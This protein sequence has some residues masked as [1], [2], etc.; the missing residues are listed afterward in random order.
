MNLGWDFVIGV[1][2]VL[3]WLIRLEA[4]VLYMEK[5]TVKH[6]EE[7]MSK[8]EKL[9][10]KI[11]NMNEKMQTVLTALAKLEGYMSNHHENKNN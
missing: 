7:S 10:D 3:I 8:E 9:W 6:R 5:D 1:V 4:K 11:D 2:L